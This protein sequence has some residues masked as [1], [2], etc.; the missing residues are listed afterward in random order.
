M[1]LFEHIPHPH[2]PRNVNR[3]V[4]MERETAGFNSRVAVAMTKLFQAMPVFWLIMAWIAVWILANITIAHFDPMPFPLL[5]ALASIPQLPLMIV[6]MVGQGVLGRHQ[7]LQA[8]EQYQTTGKSSHDIEQLAA[9]LVAQDAV[10]LAIQAQLADS[11]R[12]GGVL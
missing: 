9:H 11:V 5:L 7:E 8:E 10:L 6:I 3:L 1:K 12:K 4:E 2:Q